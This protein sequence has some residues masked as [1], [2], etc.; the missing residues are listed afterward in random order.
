MHWNN[1][2][3]NVIR[4]LSDRSSNLRGGSLISRVVLFS[5]EHCKV[6]SKDNSIKSP[7]KS[8]SRSLIS[9]SVLFSDVE[10]KDS[11]TDRKC[12]QVFDLDF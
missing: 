6:F 10:C 9:S 12:C 11:Q 4:F 5:D 8:D 3:C 7:A 1:P 2:V